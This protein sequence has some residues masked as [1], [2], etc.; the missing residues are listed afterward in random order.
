MLEQTAS[1]RG[2]IFAAIP[3]M[4]R[5]AGLRAATG[6]LSIR[7][8]DPVMRCRQIAIA[9]I[10]TRA[11]FAPRDRATAWMRSDSD[12]SMYADFRRK[13]VGLGPLGEP[14]RSHALANWSDQNCRSW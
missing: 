1:R 5:N 13:L 12:R 8:S 9:A 11:K 2:T 10:K 7:S 3:G 14:P 6:K 4:P